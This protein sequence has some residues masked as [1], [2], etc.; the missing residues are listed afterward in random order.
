M[1]LTYIANARFPSEKAHR[2]KIAKILEA[3]IL[4]GVKVTPV[5]PKKNHFV[6][7]AWRTIHHVR[8]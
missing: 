5:F 7:C 2:I 3:L 1:R 8:D 4:Q 6:K